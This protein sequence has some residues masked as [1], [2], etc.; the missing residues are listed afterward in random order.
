MVKHHQILMGFTIVTFVSGVL[1]YPID[2][3]K[4]VNLHPVFEV[5]EVLAMD[6]KPELVQSCLDTAGDIPIAILVVSSAT[7]IAA[8]FLQGRE[9]GHW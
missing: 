9:V 4:C 6:P 5:D 7:G 1:L 3:D 8:V 2:R